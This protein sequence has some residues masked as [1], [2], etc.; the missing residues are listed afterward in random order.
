MDF[1]PFGKNS[2]SGRASARC[3]LRDGARLVARCVR[4]RADQT[5]ESFVRCHGEAFQRFWR[6]SQGAVL[7]D[8]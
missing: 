7:Y 1:S 3:L 6:R 8:T 4:A 5:L 2:V